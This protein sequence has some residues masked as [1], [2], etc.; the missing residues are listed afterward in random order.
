[1]RSAYQHVR[2]GRKT[3]QPIG[4][5]K[6]DGGIVIGRGAGLDRRLKVRRDV[7]LNLSNSRLEGVRRTV[8]AV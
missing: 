5:V 4:R 7:S 6:L 3:T 1:M 8:W 2:L